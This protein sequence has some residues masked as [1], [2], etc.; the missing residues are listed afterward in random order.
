[1]VKQIY[2]R[3]SLKL[4]YAQIL[5]RLGESIFEAGDIENV[6]WT[7]G[8]SPLKITLIR[9]EP[10]LETD[11]EQREYF[12]DWAMDVKD[13]FPEFDDPDVNRHEITVED[14]PSNNNVI[15]NYYYKIESTE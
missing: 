1:M 14:D 8:N 7:S 13:A 3:K 9:D 15:F 2:L 6:S 5:T 4:S 12:Y 10:L 11:L